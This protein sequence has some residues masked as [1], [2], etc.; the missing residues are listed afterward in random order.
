MRLVQTVLRALLACT[1]RPSAEISRGLILIGNG[2]R[3]MSGGD[4]AVGGAGAVV[5]RDV[6]PFTIVG[7]NPARHIRAR[8]DYETT[9]R[10]H[11]LQWWT[12]PDEWLL[13]EADFL[14]EEHARGQ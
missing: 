10:L 9:V 8:F 13:A 12:W 3:L 7:S 11:A 14:V 2:A 4:G 6:A 5:A 1:E